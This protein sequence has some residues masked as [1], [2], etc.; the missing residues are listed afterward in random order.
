MNRIQRHDWQGEY[1]TLLD[2]EGKPVG[3]G[4]AVKDFRGDAHVIK[5]EGHTAPHKLGAS[6]YVSTDFGRFYA[7]VFDFV[8]GYDHGRGEAHHE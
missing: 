2:K 6:G 1:L 5:A 4:Q 3:V 8:W 7:S